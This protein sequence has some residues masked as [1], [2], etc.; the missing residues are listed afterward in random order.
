MS[1]LQPGK[2]FGPYQVISQIGQGGMATVFRAYHAAMDRYVALKILPYQFA[3]SPEF[4]G[5][6][7]QEARLIARLEHPHILPVYDFGESDN[8]PYLVMRL[9]DAGSLVERIQVGPMALADIDHI[10][11]QVAD[12][13]AYAHE[14]GV[15]HR[16]IKPSNVMLDRHGGVFL[17]DFGIARLVEGSSQFTATG[18][19]TGTPA[20][21]SPEQAQG[22]QLNQRTDVYSLGI[23]LYEMLT[24]RVPFEAETP[25][26]VILKKVQEP[27]PPPSALQPGID[28][29]IERVVLRALARDPAERY[30]NVREFLQSWKE[31][32]SR[33][34]RGD[35]AEPLPVQG[36]PARP[37]K[38]EPAAAP[39]S[40]E[41]LATV[42]VQAAPSQPPPRRR[43]PGWVWG[44]LILLLILILAIIGIVWSGVFGKP[45][46]TPTPSAL[47]AT[48][49]PVLPS[50][51]LPPPATQSPIPPTLP[52]TP[53]EATL[54]P[55]ALPAQ[56]TD[57]FGAAMVLVEAGPFTMGDDGGDSDERPAHLVTLAGYYIDQ[58]EVTNAQY[59]RCVAE[60]ACSPP[61]LSG[62]YTRQTYYGE[63]EYAAFPVIYVSW[64][65]AQTY[66]AW[67]GARLPTEAEWEK[68]ARG[69]EGQ[70]YPWGEEL[71]C[72][73]ANYNGC[74]PDT[75][76][77]GSYPSSASP[78]GAYDMSGNVN[79]WVA[80]WYGVDYY[81][82]SPA[83]NP[84]G[85]AMGE[86]RVLRGGSF[87]DLPEFAR[88]AARLKS[89]PESADSLVGFRCASSISLPDAAATGAAPAQISDAAGV[90]MA[91]IPAGPFTMG[92]SADVGLAECQLLSMRSRQ[93]ERS[94]FLNE[95]PPHVVTLDD[96][97]IDL[98]EVT[99]A[100]YAA[101]VSAGVC[102]PP[103]KN[104]SYTRSS[105]YDNPQYADYPV[106]EVSWENARTYCEWRGARLPTEAEWEKAARGSD[107]RLYP[108][109]SQFDGHLANF[110]DSNCQ[111]DWANRDFD[112]GYADT[113]P[114]GSYPGGV[115]PYGVYD[116]AGNVWEW[117]ADWHAEGYYATL[118][119]GA[120][121]PGGPENGDGRVIRGGSWYN[122]GDVLL[123]THRGWNAPETQ[124]SHFGFRCARS[125][126]NGAGDPTVAEPLR[127]TANSGSSIQ[128]AFSP[129]GERIVFISDRDGNQEIYVMNRDGSGQQRLTFTNDVQEDLPSFSP[130]GTQILF[131]GTVGG[132][133]DLYLMRSD[134]SQMVNLTNTPGSNE[135]RPHFSPSGQ[136][137]LYDSD[138][139]GNWEIYL[140]RL[141][142]GGLS[143][144]L[145]LTQRP[146]FNNRL[147]SFSPLG[148]WIIFRSV[149]ITSNDSSITLVKPDGSGLVSLSS[150]EMDYYPSISP[151][152]QAILFISERDGNAE[153]YLMDLA[154][155]NATRLTFDEAAQNFAVF[156]PQGDWIA[157]ATQGESGG[158]D[159]YLMPYPP[160]G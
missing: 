113:A 81:Q 46:A 24:G 35:R 111:Q 67:R 156:A 32:L 29:G 30:A 20:Y 94:L 102:L 82:R 59:A 147:A 28:P 36:P 69:A 60:G 101:C 103:G 112:D 14:Q 145:R 134:G 41:E 38:V 87:L 8:V 17:T 92:S 43:I 141:E 133:E 44:L 51:T 153:I 64:A 124:R 21:M 117:V 88:A 139:S 86:M 125:V 71:R 132:Y 130:D 78:Y 77:V 9:L 25:L 50:A 45:T 90:P 107:G 119:A 122:A 84:S 104:E 62:S 138:G 115:S 48:P 152:G 63:P 47:A 73:Y 19:I 129:D 126:E 6:F 23:V 151:D 128:P 13:L 140:A 109:G 40:V 143:E 15:I 118:E 57:A 89:V 74:T 105:Y 91:L 34:E 52:P 108:W 4:L 56:I 18:T 33:R 150:G 42:R 2:M 49:S 159:I 31:A 3:H 160:G 96:Y 97:Y 11:S 37:V 110:C 80:D 157:F 61:E 58:Y 131:G 16:D 149:V 65:D 98:Y 135:G 85:P 137:I 123:I 136:F 53:V 154:G 127:L 5:R 114:V 72:A 79:E 1:D 144:V 54:P 106:I 116:M 26:A 55:T 120:L 93:C 99:N 76:A 27:P 146:D 83:E 12:A 66:C 39:A 155:E 95:E 121:N 68:A 142:A 158:Y 22:G 75:Q 7:R 70:T 148:D 10:L 100:R